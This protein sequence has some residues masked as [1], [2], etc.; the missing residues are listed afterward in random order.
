MFIQREQE[1]LEQEDRPTRRWRGWVWVV[2]SM[3]QSLDPSAGEQASESQ[4]VLDT[5]PQAILNNWTQR[6]ETD[7]DRCQ[8][9]MQW[10]SVR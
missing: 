9:D 3:N 10:L 6:N 5:G 2:I 1:Q 8:K 7:R 4:P